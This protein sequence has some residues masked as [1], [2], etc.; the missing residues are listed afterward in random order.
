LNGND[1][2]NR[3]PN[4]GGNYTLPASLGPNSIVYL[5]W[6]DIN[7]PNSDPLMAMDNFAFSA[8]LVNEPVTLGITGPTNNQAI[9][10][11][12]TIPVTTFATGTIEGVGFYV[13]GAYAGSDFVSPFTASLPTTGLSLGNHTISAFATNGYDQRLCDKRKWCSCAGHE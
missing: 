1:P 11:T 10:Q 8:I 13:D 4:I 3:V 5:R 7:D 2:A 12:G 9:P 6:V